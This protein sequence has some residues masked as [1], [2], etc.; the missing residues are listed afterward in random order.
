MQFE[1]PP[2]KSEREK[3]KEEFRKIDELITGLFY[4]LEKKEVRTDEMVE[5]EEERQEIYQEAKGATAGFSEIIQKYKNNLEKIRT[6]AQEDLG[7]SKEEVSDQN[8]QF[9]F[10]LFQ[11]EYIADKED[12][13]ITEH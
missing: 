8:L 2:Q 5:L 7:F 9:Y 3:F 1:E 12:K 11:Q 10:L 6:L 4:F 13:T